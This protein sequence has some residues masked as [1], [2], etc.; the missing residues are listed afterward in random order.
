MAF[1]QISSREELSEKDTK[2][3]LK[4]MFSIAKAKFP[5]FLLVI[6]AIQYCSTYQEVLDRI[7]KNVKDMSKSQL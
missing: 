5:S 2:H 7:M 4:I 3:N 1:I 6:S